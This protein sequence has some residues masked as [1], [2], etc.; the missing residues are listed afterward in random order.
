MIRLS[1]LADYGVQLMTHMAVDRERLNSTQWLT[2]ATG[3]ATPTVSKILT[4]LTR[5]GLLVSHRG[6]RGGYKLA[7]DPAHISVGEI[8]AALDGPI[9]L[10][11]CV[12]HGPGVCGVESFCLSR[13]SW[14]KLNAAVRRAL[15][16]VSLAEIA[17]PAFLSPPSHRRADQ[18]QA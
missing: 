7:R 13:H 15:D 4:A 12:E 2:A 1:R 5:D 8:I 11:V 14:H 17:A 18:P 6:A 3:L 9:A 16:E 10:T